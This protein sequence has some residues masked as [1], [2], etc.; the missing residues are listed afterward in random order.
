M[1]PYVDFCRQND[2]VLI[3]DACE[4]LG[5]HFAGRHVGTFGPMGA[6]SCYF[7]HHISTIEGGVVI[8]SDA[9]LFDDLQSLRAHGWI[10]D[11]GD[12][13]YWKEQYPDID[14]RFLFITGGYNVRP[15]E[16]QAAV[17][18]VQLR[19]LDQMLASRERLACRVRDW[20]AGSAPGCG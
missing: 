3:E 13:A 16:I 2:L 10:R 4:S 8:T 11:R 19:K 18:R 7:S 1:N 5:G 12:A 17:G 15:T 6:F 14:P 20:V 9:E